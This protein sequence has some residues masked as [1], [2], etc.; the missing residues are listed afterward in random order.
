MRKSK[1]T[2]IGIILIMASFYLSSCKNSSIEVPV[3]SKNEF[4]MNYTAAKTSN[5]LIAL[6]ENKN[7]NVIRTGLDLES[8][9]S[10]QSTALSKLSNEQLEKF[11]KGIVFKENVG[12]VG[13]NYQIL[14]NSLAADDFAEV[15]ALFGLDV[16]HGFWGFSSDKNIAEKLSINEEIRGGSARSLMFEDYK[17]YRCESP[18]NCRMN[19]DYICLTGC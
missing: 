2:M 8:V 15:M 17:G 10:S 14:N 3:K 18:H 7:A 19:S 12:V 1:K 16:K 6:R 9:I 4:K 13:F 5:E 11:M